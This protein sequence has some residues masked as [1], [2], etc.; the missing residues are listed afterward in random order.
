MSEQV[1][2][3]LA[4]SHFWYESAY[5]VLL[6]ALPRD[7]HSH[8]VEVGVFHGASLAWLCAAVL[9]SGKPVTLHGVDDWS[10]WDGEA[11]GEALQLSC[12]TALAPYV[13][14][15]GSRLLLHSLPS[16]RAAQ[17]FADRSLSVVWL[18][19]DHSYEAVRQDIA[20]W[21]P[22]LKPGGTLGGDDYSYSG[23]A[24]ATREAFGSRLILGDGTRH[25]ARWPW[26][27]VRVGG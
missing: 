5:R 27:M 22:K 4:P 7:T 18:D 16:T 23:V 11:S 24:K 19:A 13:E 25:R 2:S 14:S 6:D 12:K 21:L 26:W 8:W 9:E 3:P 10:S 15:L 20:A 17:T 1:T